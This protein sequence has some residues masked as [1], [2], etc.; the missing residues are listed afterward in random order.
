MSILALSENMKIFFLST[1]RSH[2]SVEVNN[3]EPRVKISKFNCWLFHLLPVTFCYL[4]I[5]LY[6]DFPFI[7]E[8]FL[9]SI[10]I[11][12]SL[13]VSAKIGILV[14]LVISFQGTYKTIKWKCA[15]QIFR[16][17]WGLKFPC[18]QP[19][20]YLCVL[21]ALQNCENSIATLHVLKYPPTS[22]PLQGLT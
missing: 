1:Y 22:P 18:L 15:K 20:K 17:W 9:K 11:Q 7:K 8:K 3:I 2:Y 21:S 13:L 14:N 10:Y 16:W 6:L 19:E 4:W 5:T 12:D